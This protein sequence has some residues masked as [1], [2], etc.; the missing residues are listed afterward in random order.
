[1]YYY[2]ILN[3]DVETINLI[4]TIHSALG[5]PPPQNLFSPNEAVEEFLPHLHAQEKCDIC[6]ECS[7]DGVVINPVYSARGPRSLTMRNKSG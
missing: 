6:G 7:G 4:T 1:M 5:H 2:H 3:R